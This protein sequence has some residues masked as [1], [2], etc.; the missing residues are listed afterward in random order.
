MWGDVGLLE[1]CGGGWEGSF[2]RGSQRLCWVWEVRDEGVCREMWRY[3]FEGRCGYVDVRGKGVRWM[4]VKEWDADGLYLEGV[5][6][7]M[8]DVEEGGMLGRDMGK[9][10]GGEEVYDDK[11]RSGRLGYVGEEY[12]RV[13][14]GV[15]KEG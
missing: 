2:C 8:L 12:I 3:V 11:S 6:E 9:C 13:D 7:S 14:E 10:R 5:N 15:L 4:H 1:I